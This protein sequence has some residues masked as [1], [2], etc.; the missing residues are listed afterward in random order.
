MARRSKTN[1]S[2]KP[3][4][5]EATTTAPKVISDKTEKAQKV[6]A[7]AAAKKEIDHNINTGKPITGAKPKTVEKPKGKDVKPAE[8]PKKVS[9]PRLSV[10]I[11]ELIQKGGKWDDLLA[12]ANKFC[13]EQGLRTVVTVGS[14][15]TQV[16]W[17]T[18]VQKQ[19]DYIKGLKFTD[20]GIEKIAKPKK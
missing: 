5:M 13:K 11:D 10:K 2:L 12:E 1:V 16:H 9:K 3:K 20:K 14:F 15:K 6:L 8:K 17:R 18:V 7:Q 4:K 19:A